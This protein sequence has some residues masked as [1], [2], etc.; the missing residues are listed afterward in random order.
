MKTSESKECNKFQGLRYYAISSDQK[1]IAEGYDPEMV[2]CDAII[3]GEKCPIIIS[4]NT[5]I[6]NSKND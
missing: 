1:I 3:S 6:K 2:R 4:S 5:I